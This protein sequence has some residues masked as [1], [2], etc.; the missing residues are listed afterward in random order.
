MSHSFN[1]L[2]AVLLL[3]RLNRL[4]LLVRTWAAKTKMSLVSL[5]VHNRKARDA[6][7]LGFIRTHQNAL[8][9]HTNRSNH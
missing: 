8:V 7:K 1:Q 3:G 9:R 4:L 5:P 2:P 6:F